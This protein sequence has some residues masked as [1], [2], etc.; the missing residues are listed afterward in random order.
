MNK[1]STCTECGANSRRGEEVHL[2]WC[3]VWKKKHGKIA[4]EHTKKQIKRMKKEG[5]DAQNVIQ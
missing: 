5:K 3:V 2:V 4:E 1:A